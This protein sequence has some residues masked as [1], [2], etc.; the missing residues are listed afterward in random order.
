MTLPSL[1]L[2]L[3]A[4]RGGMAV[5]H[6]LISQASQSGL[7]T[8]ATR[9]KLERTLLKE[10]WMGSYVYLE[11]RE[12]KGCKYFCVGHYSPDGTFIP[13]KDFPTS[14]EAAERVAWL[15]GSGRQPLPKGDDDEQP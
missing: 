8:T 7:P 12:G 15:N 14:N 11:I 1:R 4:C 5:R 10:G 9:I 6:T 13:E 2:S 3:S